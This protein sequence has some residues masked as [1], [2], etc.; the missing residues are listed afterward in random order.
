MTVDPELY[1]T[2]VFVLGVTWLDCSM[3]NAK[4]MGSLALLQS[5]SGV[6]KVTWKCL[7]IVRWKRT[8]HLGVYSNS[9]FIEWVQLPGKLY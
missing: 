5:T 1:S 3:F 7:Y 4:N 8:H 9:I 2:I 6:E